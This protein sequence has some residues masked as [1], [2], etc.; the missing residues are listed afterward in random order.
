MFAGN[1]LYTSTEV[2]YKLLVKPKI[3]PTPKGI[4]G[5]FLNCEL[6]ITNTSPSGV[7]GATSFSPNELF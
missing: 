1:R 3:P 7:R 5:I 2:K 6:R 4:E